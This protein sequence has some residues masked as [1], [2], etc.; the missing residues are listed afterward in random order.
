MYNVVFHCCYSWSSSRVFMP[1]TYRYALLLSN[2]N[3]IIAQIWLPPIPEWLL[4]AIQLVT[5]IHALPS[6]PPE[7]KTEAT[8]SWTRLSFVQ[9]VS[10][11]IYKRIPSQCLLILLPGFLK[12]KI[13]FL[14]SNTFSPCPAHMLYINFQFLRA[15]QKKKNSCVC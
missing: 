3:S 6:E 15:A 13:P 8:V 7:N 14:C 11:Y 10:S 9:F 5:T 2:G 12:K 1:G 4:L